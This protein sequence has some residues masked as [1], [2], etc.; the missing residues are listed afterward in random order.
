[1]KTKLFLAVLIFMVGSWKVNA[2]YHMT[3]YNDFGGLSNEG[4]I[5]VGINS[6]PDALQSPVDIYVGDGIII[7]LEAYDDHQTTHGYE[8]VFNDGE[9]PNN[10][11]KWYKIRNG[12]VSVIDSLQSV[13][14]QTYNDANATIYDTQQRLF[15]V[16]RDDQ[17]EFGT[18]SATSVGKV[19]EENSIQVCVPSTV[20]RNGKTLYFAGWK[21]LTSGSNPLTVTPPDDN[22][23]YTAQYKG[24]QLSDN[25]SVYIYPAERNY[26]QSEN[27]WTHMVYESMGHVWYERKAP[28]GSWQLVPQGGTANP[29]HLDD[30]NGKSPAIDFA[31]NFPGYPGLVG[32]VYQ[33]GSIIHLKTWYYSASNGQYYSWQTREISTGE[34]SSYHLRPN[35]AWGPDNYV[36]VLW[37][38][39]SGLKY[40]QIDMSLSNP[41]QTYSGT[42]PGTNGNSIHAAIS[43]DKTTLGGYDIAWEQYGT[44]GSNTVKIYLCV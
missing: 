31:V 43:D 25:M 4:L 19:V 41:R 23:T 18:G 27:D 9:G 35:I 37:E 26:I 7:N 15:Q 38:S 28:G 14:Y 1:M 2:Q 34:S 22:T 11:S 42:I 17:T 3:I 8:W 20:T 44:T 13:T 16:Y 24:L 5:G 6:Q 39:P 10:Y 30:S 33:E 29:I 12:N 32:I 21:G 36:M 40:V